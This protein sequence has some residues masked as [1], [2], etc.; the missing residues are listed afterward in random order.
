MKKFLLCFVIVLFFIFVFV[1][2]YNKNISVKNNPLKESTSISNSIVVGL[3]VTPKT[4][5]EL[6][7]IASCVLN[8]A[9]NT[10]LFDAYTFQDLNSLW[11]ITEISAPFECKD[12]FADKYVLECFKCDSTYCYSICENESIGKLFIFYKNI[13]NELLALRVAVCKEKL[14]FSDFSNLSLHKSTIDDVQNIDSTTN[15]SYKYLSSSIHKPETKNDDLCGVSTHMTSEGIILIGYVDVNGVKYIDCIEKI[16]D[17][18]I[19]MVLTDKTGD[20]S[21]SYRETE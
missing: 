7:E 12:V 13:D 9:H 15:F 10:N 2:F 1:Y 19:Q 4:E 8:R 6:R 5:D 20:G 18:L 21:V 3:S 17:P 16:E 11:G 14:E